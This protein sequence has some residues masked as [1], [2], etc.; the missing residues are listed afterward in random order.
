[1]FHLFF[2]SIN[3]F[4]ISEFIYIHKNLPNVINKD[5]GNNIIKSGVNYYSIHKIMG[6]IG[7]NK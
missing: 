2:L 5:D 3:T 6:I 7:Y 4:R 1:M